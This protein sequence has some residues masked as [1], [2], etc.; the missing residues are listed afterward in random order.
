[1]MESPLAMQ[2][3]YCLVNKKPVYPSPPSH[4]FFSGASSKRRNASRRLPSFAACCSAA[5]C[6]AACCSC[7]CP[8][9]MA[10]ALPGPT[11][12]GLV[13]W[14]GGGH[15][16][17]WWIYLQLFNRLTYEWSS[18]RPDMPRQNDG[19]LWEVGQHI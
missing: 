15:G 4:T 5:C 1:M 12:A 7:F 17:L 8:Q 9:H 11:P 18:L 10:R 13:C 19:I 2:V 14:F 16:C 6:S 3:R